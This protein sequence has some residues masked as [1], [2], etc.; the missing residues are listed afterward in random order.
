MTVGFLMII[1]LRTKD[2][3]FDC[4]FLSEIYTKADPKITTS[5]TVPILWDK[6]LNTI[7][8]NESSEIIRMFN[9]S[10]NSLTGN[11]EDFIRKSIEKKLMRLN[12]K[13][14]HDVNNGVYKC[15]FL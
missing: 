14:Y 4:K 3:L 1:T 7:V 15:G 6:K 8:N 5:V 11:K 12:D 9:T 10:F 13:I 2:D